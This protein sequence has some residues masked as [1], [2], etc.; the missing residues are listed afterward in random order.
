MK[1]LIGL[2]F[3]SLLCFNFSIADENKELKLIED[4]KNRLFDTAI[5]KD[6][7]KVEEICTN[8]RNDKE[9]NI[10]AKQNMTKLLNHTGKTNLPLLS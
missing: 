4:Y 10:I 2:I 7:K 3:L 5:K 1:K 8:Y 6:L 9:K